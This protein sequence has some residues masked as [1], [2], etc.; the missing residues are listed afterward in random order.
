MKKKNTLTKNGTIVF[1]LTTFGSAINYL[2]QL[3]TGRYFSVENY[4]IINIIFSLTLIV[5]LCFL[6]RI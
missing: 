6:F 2:F 1:I 5:L 4:G 3:L